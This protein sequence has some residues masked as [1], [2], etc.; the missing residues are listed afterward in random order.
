MN[1]TCLYT[2]MGA[3]LQ[4]IRSTKGKDLHWLFL[5]GG[6][7]LGSESLILLCNLLQLPGTIWRLD[8]PGDGSNTTSNNCESFSHWS[9]ALIEAVSQFQHVIV[10]AHSTGGMYVLST[11]KIENLLD[12]LI[13]LDSA[14]HAEWQSS[15]G[16]MLKSASIPEL[17]ALQKK[18]QEAP[19][20]EIL[21][22]MTLLSAPY[23]FTEKG[24]TEGIKMLESLPYNYE[25]CQW[26]EEHFDQ[27]Y[28]AQWIPQT[29]PTLILCG[30]QD[31]VTPSHLFAEEELF[32]RD[33]IEIKSIKNAGHF[34]WI[35]NPEDV[36]AAFKEYCGRLDFSSDKYI[37][38]T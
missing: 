28:R 8:L 32:H 9:S 21:R 13:L 7:G 14:P 3:R 24:L 31:L 23:L 30:E 11:P 19:S 36:A 35:E 20:N 37:E 4:W 16:T 26:S 18:Y 38:T 33:N 34:P 5:P 10:V 22:K 15:F 2:P 1:D 25:V 29:I 27:T 12:G 17:E 6:P